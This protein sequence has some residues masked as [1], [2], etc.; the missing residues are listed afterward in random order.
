MPPYQ[1][2][3]AITFLEIYR[4]LHFMRDGDAFLAHAKSNPT[5]YLARYQAQKL[6]KA[7]VRTA[8]A[9]CLLEIKRCMDA[10]YLPV[11]GDM[12]LYFKR[13]DDVLACT[14]Y[15]A[16]LIQRYNRDYHGDIDTHSLFEWVLDEL[17]RS[18]RR[19]RRGE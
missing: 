7:E 6:P 15:Y 11:H 10:L 5:I 2:L 4:A 8:L 16:A 9:D 14:A 17:V 13:V 19:L 1:N 3:N 12:F 18:V